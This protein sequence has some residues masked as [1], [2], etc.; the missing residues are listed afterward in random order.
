MSPPY[1]VSE[2]WIFELLARYKAE[3]EAAFEPRSRRPEELTDRDADRDRGADPRATQEADRRRPGRRPGHHRVAPRAPPPDRRCPGRRSRDPE[4][5]RPGGPGADEEAQVL[6]HPLRRRAA[7]RDLAVRLHPLPAHP[8]R[9]STRRGLRDPDLARR[10]LPLRPHGHRAP[11]G[12]RPDSADEP[13][14]KPLHRTGFPPPHSPT[15]AWSTPP[16]CP[17]RAGRAPAPATGSRPNCA[18][19]TSS[20]RTGD[21][22]TRPPTARSSG[23]SRR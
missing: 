8:P 21:P 11:P 7:Q 5:S 19:S 15:T 3:G 6:L 14:A 13:S 1:G 22:T 4:P 2:S 10:L 16:G 20:R 18:V 9:R 12:H 23:S 17:A